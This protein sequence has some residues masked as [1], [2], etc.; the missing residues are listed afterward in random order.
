MNAATF[1]PMPEGVTGIYLSL[2]LP[3]PEDLKWANFSVSPKKAKLNPGSPA[4]GPVFKWSLDL[5]AYDVQGGKVLLSTTDF[6][7]KKLSEFFE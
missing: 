6:F 5:I 4:K 3:S 2:P 1:T 7:A